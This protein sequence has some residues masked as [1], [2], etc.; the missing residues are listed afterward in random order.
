MAQYVIMPK[1]IVSDD[2]PRRPIVLRTCPPF[3]LLP[4]G[5]YITFTP[6]KFAD[7]N[8]YN[9]NVPFND[10]FAAVDPTVSDDVTKNFSPGSI[11]IN[12]TSKTSFVCTDNTIGA[13]VWVAT[14]GG[15]SPPFP[16]NAALVEN[17]SDNTKLLIISAASITTGTTRTLT[18]PD[19]DGTIACLSDLSSSI[20]FADEAPSGTIDGTNP[21]FTLSQTPIANSLFL[22]KSGLF[23]T[24]DTLIDFT[25]SGL[26]ITFNAGSIPVTGQTLRAKYAVGGG[27]GGEGYFDDGYFGSYF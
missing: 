22:F 13:A 10:F 21:T 11:K 27:G 9:F 23:M 16:D 1:Q 6:P 15:S 25:L 5:K 24:L 7:G 26:T 8:T 14:G 12:R 2:T 20:T 18:A 17:N 3:S 19:K 4:Q